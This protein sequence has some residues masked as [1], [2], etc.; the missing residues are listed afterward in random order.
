MTAEAVDHARRE[1][2]REGGHEAQPLEP[3]HRGDGVEQVGEVGTLAGC[4][5]RLAPVVHRLAQ[6]LDLDEAVVDQ[7]THLG[8]HLGQRSAAFRAAGRRHDAEGA[9]LVA[10]LDHRHHP[11]VVALA[12][13]RVEDVGALLR[14]AG[15]DHPLAGAPAVED[16]GQLPH[17][18]RPEDEVE[19]GDA[20]QRA[21]PRLLRDA[22]AEADHHAGPRLL[23]A[24]VLA[25]A[26]VHLLLRL[27]AHAA[28]VEQDDV[29]LLRLAG[30]Q[31]A[32]LH[33]LPRHAL[34][35]ELV[36]LA[37]PGFDV[38]APRGG[39]VRGAARRRYNLDVPS[40]VPSV[41]EVRVATAIG[42]GRHCWSGSTASSSSTGGSIG[43]AVSVV[44][45]S[46]VVFGSSSMP[47]R[48]QP[49]RAPA[50]RPSSISSSMRSR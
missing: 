14:E 15:G 30:R 40:G 9:A 6:Q 29:R 33:E 18:R 46:P 44:V 38:E 32:L 4:A 1:V 5:A 17:P 11:L 13:D 27:L 8:H 39:A 25:E 47:S 24:P 2:A 50:R 28:R 41:K 37:A 23:V 45:S 20:R 34:A 22:A 16:R 12:R 31:D 21:L 36:H 7:V 26:R 49:G 35:V 48:S 19:V 42:D 10:A 3:R 43:S